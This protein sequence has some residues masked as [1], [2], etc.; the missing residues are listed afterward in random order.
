[1]DRIAVILDAVRLWF[2]NKRRFDAT[3]ILTQYPTQKRVFLSPA[4]VI[5]GAGTLQISGKKLRVTFSNFFGDE[6]PEGTKFGPCKEPNHW[7]V[8]KLIRALIL[9]KLELQIN[10]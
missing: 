6:S 7:H 2:G 4:E 9:L 5:G 1:M 3:H 10:C 8:T